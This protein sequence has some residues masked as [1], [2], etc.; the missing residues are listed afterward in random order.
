MLL[1]EVD[2]GKPSG[3]GSS[4]GRVAAGA[5]RDPGRFSSRR[6]TEAVLRL[7]RGEALD[8]LARELGVTAAT[9]SQWREQFLAGG[10]AAVKSRAADARDDEIGRLRAKVGEI[11]MANELLRERCH[12]LEA[13]LPPALRRSRA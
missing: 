2:M 7:V 5:D 8:A 13:G 10:Q 6:K 3:S 1:T 12:R 9:L 11:T 4:G